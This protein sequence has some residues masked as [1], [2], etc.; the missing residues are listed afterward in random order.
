MVEP[1]ARRRIKKEA[2]L[3]FRVFAPAPHR[4][5]LVAP[6][7]HPR[8]DP[9]AGAAG[10]GGG[11]AVAGSMPVTLDELGTVTPVATVTVLPQISG[12]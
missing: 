5:H 4:V 12:D 9:C 6:F 11:K 10:G 2:G 1:V 3:D 7:G 8:E